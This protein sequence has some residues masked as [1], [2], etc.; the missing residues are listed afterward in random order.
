MSKYR[1]LGEKEQRHL[2]RF[3]RFL[4]PVAR[5][6]NHPLSHMARRQIAV[7]L[8]RW[9]ADAVDDEGIVK[10]DTFKYNVDVH[11]AT[12]AAREAQRA[13][14]AGLRHEHAVPRMVLAR[15]II[16]ENL[17]ED[18]ILSFLRR[19]CVAVVVTKDEDS[20]LKPKNEMP[21]DWDWQ[22][23][24]CYARYEFSKIPILVPGGQLRSW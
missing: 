18:E 16:D 11:A 22:T 5:D 15:R 6:G 2:A 19:Y 10:Q 8:W 17:E 12:P 24:H 21:R 14:S 9:T 3:I 23:G 13:G 20:R 1:P 7:W 4:V